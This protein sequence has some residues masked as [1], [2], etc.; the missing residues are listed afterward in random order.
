MWGFI[1]VPEGYY[2]RTSALTADQQEIS[3]A[4][5]LNPP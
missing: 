1:K 2:R 3:T 4:L 5:E